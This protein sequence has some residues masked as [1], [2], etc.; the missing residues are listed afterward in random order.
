MSENWKEMINDFIPN[1]IPG[2]I[3]RSRREALNLSLKSL[4]MK[5]QIEATLISKYETGELAIT[6][7][8]AAALARPLG[9]SI[10]TILS[11]DI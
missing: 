9:I 6:K 5:T 10:S 11:T 4:E 8:V 3:I 7:E 1:R 2:D